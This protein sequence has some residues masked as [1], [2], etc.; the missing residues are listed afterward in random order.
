MRIYDLRLGRFLS[1]DP[2]GS[3][4]PMLTPYQF[5]SNTPIQAIDLDGLEAVNWIKAFG[6][7]IDKPTLE[8]GHWYRI[9][10]DFGVGRS[11]AVHNE[12]WRAAEIY[13]AK[14]IQPEAYSTIEERHDFYNSAQDLLSQKSIDTKWF[15]TAG[16]VTGMFAVGGAEFDALNIV[17]DDDAKNFFIKGNEY[18]FSQNIRTFND[19]FTTGKV[20]ASFIIAEGKNGRQQVDLPKLSGK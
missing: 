8:S 6:L 9:I 19:L 2:I 5:A 11:V 18:L 10:N 13:N 7:T 12:S 16:V 14:N 20:N 1:V 17:L 4:Y 15:Q 3:K